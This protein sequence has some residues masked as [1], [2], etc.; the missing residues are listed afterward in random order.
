MK[1]VV[2]LDPDLILNFTLPPLTLLGS[3]KVLLF[4][5]L[6]F[7]EEPKNT[8]ETGIFKTCHV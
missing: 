1:V 5:V 4:T 6:R 7:A 8:K 3:R 2:D